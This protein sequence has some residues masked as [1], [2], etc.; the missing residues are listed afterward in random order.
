MKNQI[1][2]PNIPN[3]PIYV[4]VA[5]SD[6]NNLTP[7]HS[8][9]SMH[10]H[11]EIELLKVE[12]G[13]FLCHTSDK[14]IEAHAGD[15]IYLA[16]RVPHATESIAY[17]THTSLIQF[18]VQSY[19]GV[20]LK[21]NQS[22]Y[23]FINNNEAPFHLFKRNTEENKLIQSYFN[24][25]CTEIS[26]KPLGYEHYIT[27]EI[28]SIIGLLYRKNI[29]QN[30]EA[31]LSNKYIEKI[32]PALQFIDLHYNDQ[33]TLEML[34]SELN[35]NPSYFCRLFKKATNSTFTEYLNFVRVLN[36]ELLLTS[37]SK[38]ISDIALDVGFSSISYFNRI[39]KKING[40]SPTAYKKIKYTSM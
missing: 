19:S 4:S 35:M 1:I 23:R 10:F 24:I 32:M 33:I 6:S 20:K 9:S 11:D 30:T 18:S 14:T 29:L 17:G 2:C 8:I 36:S 38:G 37:N 26:E 25:I 7:P 5:P 15:V 40:I 31:Q 13:I 12:S 27:A 39:F 16:S 34:S 3:V 21:T 22:L 28:H